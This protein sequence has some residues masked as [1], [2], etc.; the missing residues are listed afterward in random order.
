MVYI[1]NDKAFEAL[2]EYSLSGSCT[3]LDA[4]QTFEITNGDNSY[5]ATVGSDG[6]S[7]HIKFMSSDEDAC[8]DTTKSYTASLRNYFVSYN[9]ADNFT[10]TKNEDGTY[11]ATPEITFEKA[12]FT[13]IPGG[14]YSAEDIDAGLPYFNMTNL[15][16]RNSA[17]NYRGEISIKTSAK[18]SIKIIGT[19]ASSDSEKDV[20]LSFGDIEETIKGGTAAKSYKYVTDGA[21]TVDIDMT[22]KTTTF[23]ITAIVVD[24]SDTTEAEPVVAETITDKEMLTVNADDMTTANSLALPTDDKYVTTEDMASG[25]FVLMSGVTV[26]A[27]KK[28]VEGIGDF[29]HRIKLNGATVLEDGVPAN[30]AIK[31]TTDSEGVLQVTSL[32]A[33]SSEDRSWC[34]YN[35]NGDVIATQSAPAGVSG[36]VPEVSDII[37][38]PKADTYYIACP[39]KACNFYSVNV[40]TGKGLTSA[41]NGKVFADKTNSYIIVPVDKATAETN[42]EL[43]VTLGNNGKTDSTSKIFEKAVIDGCLVS[44][45]DIGSDYMYVIKIN[46]ANGNDVSNFS[47]KAIIREG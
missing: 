25:S 24:Y 23:K 44:A 33:T 5:L 14:T 1:T 15:E 47:A 36:S 40:V 31:F 32:S 20:V 37:V 8:F 39:E 2:N 29:T 46:D 38:L 27:A 17:G 4:G 9:G 22:S 30:R 11:S 3:G 45:E 18:A 16:K 10:I 34:V 42:D 19:C 13:A 6:Q 28:S 26:D 41:D 12:P 43:I 35:S 7:Y 21:E